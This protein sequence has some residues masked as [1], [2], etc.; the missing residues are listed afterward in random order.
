MNSV[1]NSSSEFEYHVMCSIYF[2][3]V[4]FLVFLVMVLWMCYSWM[5]RNCVRDPGKGP[6][7]WM[8]NWGSCN[9][10]WSEIA[11]KMR[12]VAPVGPSSN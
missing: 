11:E 10:L 12:I 8:M 7:M 2:L 6:A 3:V 4:F 1:M 5:C 9:Q